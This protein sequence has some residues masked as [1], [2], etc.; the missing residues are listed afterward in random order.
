MNKV[1]IDFEEVQD[2]PNIAPKRMRFALNEYVPYEIFHH[3]SRKIKVVLQFT[4]MCQKSK[5]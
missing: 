3:V 5:L 2:V 4:I 1:L